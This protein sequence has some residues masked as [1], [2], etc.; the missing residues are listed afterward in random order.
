M[1]RWCVLALALPAVI[2]SARSGLAQGLDRTKQP[3]AGAPAPFVFPK[4]DTTRLNNGLRVV[5][6]ENHSLPLVAVRVVVAVDS[7]DDP[8]G[9]EGLFAL[10]AGMLREGT[11]TR[12]GE[13]IA[14]EIAMLGNS[15]TSS[16][17]TTIPQNLEA[18]L[19]IAADMLMHPTFPDTALARLKATLAAARQRELQVPATVPNRV[20]LAQLFGPTHRI[21]RAAGGNDGS[22]K[23]IMRD[24]LA[25]FHSTYYRP[26]NTTLVVVGDVRP[27]NIVALASKI[28]GSWPSLPGGV[29]SPNNPVL[30]A[31]PT[32]MYL[33]DRPGVQQS[34]VF[35][36]TVGPE[37]NSP[38]F[39]ALETMAPILGA[40]AGSRL[41]DNLRGRHGYMYSGTPAT[42]AWP[43]RRMPSIIG[44]SAAVAAPKTDS[45]L[46][47][48]LQELRGMGERAPTEQEMKLAR[49]ALVD[50]LPAQ[51][52]TDDLVA[53]RLM[54]MLQTGV[55]LDF[56]NSYARRIEAVTSADV[57]AVAAKYLDSSHLV[58]V[59]AGDRKLVEP[60]LR[61]ANIAPI[62]IVD[63]AGKS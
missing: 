10:T 11:T 59:V 9:K 34:Y 53:N 50:A 60:L 33:L 24:D 54:S 12:T 16:R 38:D 14:S 5:V 29:P 31:G 40:S 2:V 22:M 35:V 36:G 26:N 4:M 39:A 28:F 57:R 48:W 63:D 41:Y 52:E 51:F 44:G 37:R 55:P 61:A 13:Q 1:S 47:E 17:F 58:I 56:Y 19:G 20:F 8:E 6:V 49:G 21:A 7:L 32:T 18:S 15:V 42:V 23:A 45:A 30:H 3:A 46:V 43:Y 27:T 62:V 25:H